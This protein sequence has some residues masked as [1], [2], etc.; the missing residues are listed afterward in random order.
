MVHYNNG[1]IYKIVCNITGAVYIGSTTKDTVSQRLS[2]HVV[3]YKH[4][5]KLDK[6]PTN[7]SSF[8][9]IKNG[10]YKIYLI[11]LFPC[12]TKDELTSR[13][14]EVIRKYKDDMICVNKYIAGRSKKEYQKDYCQQNKEALSGKQ[15]EKYSCDCGSCL[16]KSHKF[17]H[18][19]SNKHQKYIKSLVVNS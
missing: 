19:R 3:M 2:Q 16:R 7:Y 15:K 4:W 6:K 9:I 10:D 12:N 18:E 17:R 13:E 8:E 5:L 1:K 14:G 11:E